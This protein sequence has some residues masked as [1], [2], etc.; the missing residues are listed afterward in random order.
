MP[1]ENVGRNPKNQN[2]ASGSE[3][4]WIKNIRLATSK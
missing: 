4:H 3:L 1:V 2:N